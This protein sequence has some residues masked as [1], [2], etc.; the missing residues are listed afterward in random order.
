MRYFVSFIILILQRLYSSSYEF[1]AMNL[2][3]HLSIIHFMVNPEIIKF[4]FLI[5]THRMNMREENESEFQ[6]PA[7]P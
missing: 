2:S 6:T 1:E 5:K 7:G 3:V 4:S